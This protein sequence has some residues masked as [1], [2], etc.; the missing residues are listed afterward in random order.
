VR[1]LGRWEIGDDSGSES[2]YSA[3]H[4]SERFL[5][6]M[7][8][9]CMISRMVHRLSYKARLDRAVKRSPIVALVGPRQCGKTTLARQVLPP[10]HP[11]YF[12]LEDPITA[13]LMENPKTALSGL[14]G[15]VVLDEAQRQPKLFPVLR[16]LADRPDNPATFLILGSASPELSRQSSESLAGRVEIIEMQGFDLCETG[17]TDVDV[18]WQRGGFPRSFLAA[19][20]ADSFD[21]RRNFI[22]TFLER[23]LA[24]LG[25][26]MAPT[27]MGRFWT[28]LSHY[29][30]Q[31][32]NGNEI[33]A[34]M[35]IAP[36][37]ARAYLDALEQTFMIRRL[38]PWHANVN[39][40]L[41][42]SPK[43]LFRDSG[44][45]HA[46]CGIRSGSDLF[47]HPKLGASWEGF[48]MEEILRAHQP[49]Q[50][51]FYAV[52]SGCEL[53]LLLFNHGKKIGVEFKRCDVPELT[54][55]MRTAFSDLQL[56]ALWV[57]HPGERTFP[58]GDRITARSLEECVREGSLSSIA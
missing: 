33:A 22:R 55:S 42:K 17:R 38:L 37:T 20:D 56:D 44:V 15:L 29:H 57:I 49:D 47:T 11:N 26:G 31:I 13:A 35:G 5:E 8:R 58:L 32:W 40:R 45:F 24:A 7:Q 48:A 39:K 18:L 54:R 1:H 19:D 10:D 16:V 34:S 9:H 21:W 43:I 2:G 51:Y 41:V 46:L 23:D 50:A 25:F 12:D 27:A 53:D 3:E 30:G 4:R 36:N 28:M 52:H 14:K 6:I